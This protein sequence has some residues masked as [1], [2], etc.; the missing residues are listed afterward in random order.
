MD[1]P[2][3]RVLYFLRE[4]VRGLTKVLSRLFELNKKF[5]DETYFVSR[6]AR[7]NQLGSLSNP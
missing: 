6:G 4:A 5:F 3:G 1:A 7:Q 2:Y